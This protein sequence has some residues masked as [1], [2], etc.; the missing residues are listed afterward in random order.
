MEQDG[1]GAQD[2]VRDLVLRLTMDHDRSP[3][4][5]EI[6]KNPQ[7]VSESRSSARC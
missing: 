3:G 4:G 1:G 7:R 2:A 5:G 6:L